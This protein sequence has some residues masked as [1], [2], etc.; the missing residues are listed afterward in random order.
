MR[1]FQL[2]HLRAKNFF[3]FV[4]LQ[5][6]HINYNPVDVMSCFQKC[7]LKR[8]FVSFQGGFSDSE[9]ESEIRYVLNVILNCNVDFENLNLVWVS[10]A[11]QES[12]SP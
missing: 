6:M 11:C 2:C 9:G 1:I 4:S 5:T 8:L 12:A 10:P 3:L 7:F